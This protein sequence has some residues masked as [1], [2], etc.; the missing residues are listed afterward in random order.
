MALPRALGWGDRVTRMLTA[1]AAGTVA[2]SLMTKYEWGLVKVLPMRA[3][4]LLDALSGA[5]LSPPR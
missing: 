1:T 5:T 2:Y 4:L 3:H